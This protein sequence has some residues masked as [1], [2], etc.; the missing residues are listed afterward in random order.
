MLRLKDILRLVNLATVILLLFYYCQFNL[1][2]YESFT[3]QHSAHYI[4]DSIKIR[5]QFSKYIL[6]NYF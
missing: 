3:S 6:Y 1:G 5:I 2:L 4:M